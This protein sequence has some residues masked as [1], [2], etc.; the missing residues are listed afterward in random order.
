MAES[1]VDASEVVLEEELFFDD[2]PREASP[3]RDELV[4][5]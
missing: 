3:R 4:L 5:S 2:P 1:V